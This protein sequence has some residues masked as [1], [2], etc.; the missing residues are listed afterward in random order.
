M[1]IH[2]AGS[3]PLVLTSILNDG[4][5]GSG[6]GAKTLQLAGLNTDYNMVTGKLQDYGGDP[7]NPLTVTKA[8]DNGVWVLAPTE[9]NTFTGGLN[10]NGGMLGLNQYGVGTGTLYFNG[11]GVFGYGGP[12]VTLA[13]STF[14]I[15]NNQII[16][17]Q[18]K[19]NS[20]NNLAITNNSNKQ[21]NNNN[22]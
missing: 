3:G 21:H 1:N 8:A 17:N 13:S 20:N 10:V 6:I 5:S 19:T 2:A 22:K 9:S 4:Q 11:G 7:G 16:N 18:P 15:N 14:N 12:L